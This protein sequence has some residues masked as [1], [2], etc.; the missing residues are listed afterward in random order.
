MAVPPSFAGADQATETWVSP[1]V[2]DTA[3]GAPGT[4]E[5]VTEAEAV[6]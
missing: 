1:E 2:P 3:V 6:E 4:V 5:G